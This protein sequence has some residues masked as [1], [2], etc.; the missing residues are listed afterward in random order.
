MQFLP[1]VSRTT[2]NRRVKRSGA[3]SWVHTKFAAAMQVANTGS[4]PVLPDL[5]HDTGH[6]SG[7]TA[8][9]KNRDQALQMDYLL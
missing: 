3:L 1:R 9:E 8:D 7:T 2:H 4:N 6:V 5:N